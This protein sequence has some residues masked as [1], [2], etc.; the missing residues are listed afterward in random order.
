[1]AITVYDLAEAAGF[2]MRSY[3]GRG[4][5]GK[6]CLGLEID[7][8]LRAVAEL[9]RACADATDPGEAAEVLAD[10]LEQAKTDHLGMR[11]IL[12]FPGVSAWG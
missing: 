11:M 5:Y 12:Y 7:S 9:V 1:M 2:G 10:A 3:S 6:T 8:P 4:M